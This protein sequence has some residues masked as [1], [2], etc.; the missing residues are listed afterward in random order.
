MDKLGA[1]NRVD[2]RGGRVDLEEECKILSA[3]HLFCPAESIL[4][5][6]V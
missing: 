3:V 4:V 6:C 2:R 5:L 1:E